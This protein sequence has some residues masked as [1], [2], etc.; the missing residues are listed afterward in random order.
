[1][2][3][4]ADDIIIIF[5]IKSTL[6]ISKHLYFISFIYLFIFVFKTDCHSLFIYL[7]KKKTTFF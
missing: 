1:M 5:I 3:N 2:L 4:T 6:P 7:N